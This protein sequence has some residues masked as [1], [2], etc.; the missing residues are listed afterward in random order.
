MESNRQLFIIHRYS[1][2]ARNRSK[3][4]CIR[5]YAFTHATHATHATHDAPILKIIESNK[6]QFTR[7]FAQHVIMS[8]G[9]VSISE[10]GKQLLAA[11][12][13]WIQVLQENGEEVYSYRL[14]D[15]VQKKYT[16]IDIIQMYKYREV[17]VDTN[18]FIGSQQLGQIEYSYF[19]GIVDRTINR[20]IVTLDFDNI[21]YMFKVGSLFFISINGFVALLIGYLFSSRLSK[22]L[23]LIIEGVRGLAGKKYDIHYAVKGIYKDVFHNVNL[24]SQQLKATEADRRRLDQMREEW[25]GNIS[26]DI[27]TPLASIQGYAELMADPNYQFTNEE[28]HEYAHIIQKNPCI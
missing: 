8:Q 12:N 19:I 24:L 15:G 28:I 5:Y 11:N 20:L 26:H 7:E 23:N 9:Q 10:E 27:K 4:N 3:H 13:A 17:N 21:L 6:E 2:Y 18:V 25:L 1:N 22:P 16:P 14:P